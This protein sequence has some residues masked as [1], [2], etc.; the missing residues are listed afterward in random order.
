[1]FSPPHSGHGRSGDT[2]LKLYPH[3]LQYPQGSRS[4]T[5]TAT[6]SH[7]PPAIHHRGT[8]AY[9]SDAD[10]AV[11]GVTTFPA[12]VIRGHSIGGHAVV[13]SYTVAPGGVVAPG[14]HHTTAFPEPI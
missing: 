10:H 1:M 9:H 13:S 6:P 7:N 11:P 14:D 2:T 4:T 3:R 5:S 8:L 12:T